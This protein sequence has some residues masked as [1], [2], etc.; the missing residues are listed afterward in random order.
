M[1]YGNLIK[2]IV[3]D[4]DGTILNANNTVSE[5]TNEYLKK[6]KDQGYIITI[7]TGRTYKSTLNAT[8]NAEFAN[9]IISNH[10]VC[11]Y[12]QIHAKNLFKNSVSNKLAEEILKY[13][14][15]DFRY[16]DI[17]SENDFYRYP[18]IDKRTILKNCKEISRISLAMKNNESVIK[19]Y[20]E[21]VNKN[22]K[23]N[24][25]LMQ[26]SFDGVKWIDIIPKNCSKYSSIKRLADSL[27]ISIN[28]IIAFGDG[29]NDLEM[30]KK[31]GRGVA[32]KNAL[33]EVKKVANEITKYDYNHD[34]V[35]KYLKEVID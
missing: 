9:Y 35:I 31:V 32:M 1:W 19:L 11:T 23:A 28:E 8:N 17:S 24:I 30:L 6:L 5:N 29:L 33:K 26:D 7:A 27:N 20:N 25:I 15:N 13:Y 12:D 10:G 3:V 22:F 21:L 4:L 2:M 18:E 16:I 14:N 34:G